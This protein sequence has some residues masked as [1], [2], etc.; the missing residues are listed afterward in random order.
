ML[1]GV[2]RLIGGSRGRSG[3]IASSVVRITAVVSSGHTLA[4]RRIVGSAR[5]DLDLLS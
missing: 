5:R 2:T 1:S 3:L 4:V